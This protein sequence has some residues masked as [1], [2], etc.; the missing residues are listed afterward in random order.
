MYTRSVW[1]GV[2]DQVAPMGQVEGL[3]VGAPGRVQLL[4]SWGRMAKGEP[5]SS[6]R[7][8]LPVASGPFRSSSRRARCSRSVRSRIG[9][10]PAPHHHL[11]AQLART[12]LSSD[13]ANPKNPPTPSAGWGRRHG[14]GRL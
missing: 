7:M 4:A 10:S 2:E 8:P 12:P 1:V 14:P 9:W 5:V 11:V 6:F 13:L 3:N